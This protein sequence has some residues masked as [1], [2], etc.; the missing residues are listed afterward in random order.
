MFLCVEVKPAPERAS[1]ELQTG[2]GVYFRRNLPALPTIPCSTLLNR[3]TYALASVSQSQTRSHMLPNAEK[4]SFLTEFFVFL[5]ITWSS[6]F[7]LQQKTQTF[8][9]WTS[10]FYWMKER[11]KK[12]PPMFLLL[13][14]LHS[15]QNATSRFTSRTSDRLPPLMLV[16]EEHPSDQMSCVKLTCFCFYLRF[17][18]CLS[19]GIF[20]KCLL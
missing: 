8:S 19:R 20:H 16:W 1:A 4:H 11:K 13:L 14:K 18:L 17:I 15:K 12:N 7:F 6:V 9:N 3:L 5:N 2:C 10:F